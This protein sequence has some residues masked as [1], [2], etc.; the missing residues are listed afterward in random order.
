MKFEKC[1]I[2]NDY[3]QK[4]IR[5]LSDERIYITGNRIHLT[6][7]ERKTGKFTEEILVEGLNKIISDYLSDRFQGC[8]LFQITNIRTVSVE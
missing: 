6:D 2:P 5:S 3:G 1:E 4:I 8:T 7:D